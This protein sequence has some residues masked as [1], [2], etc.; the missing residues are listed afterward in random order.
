[1]NNFHATLNQTFLQ[2]LDSKPDRLEI[3]IFSQLLTSK[4]KEKEYYT[5]PNDELLDQTLKN[6]KKPNKR[7]RAGLLNI[8][9]NN[10][11]S[12]DY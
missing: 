12:L 2:V 11:H 7:N 4:D 9:K 1:M 5:S 10:Q 3:F 6:F 8:V